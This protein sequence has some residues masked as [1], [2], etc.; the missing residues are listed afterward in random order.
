L[1]FKYIVLIFNII[2]VLF[3]STFA[4]IPFFFPEPESA[5][6]FRHSSW[7]LIIVLSGALIVLNVFF[8]Y[9]YR[10]FWLLER[11]DWPA[12]VDYLER[13]V[14]Q[15]GRY[16]S[17]LARLLINSYLVM[18][19]SAGVTRFESK[20]AIAKPALI[21]ENALVFGVARILGGD[22][23]GAA[24]FF[25]AH[26][27]KGAA[28]ENQW[29][30]WYYGFS[31]ILIRAFDAAEAEL[32]T[33]VPASAN[34]LITGL[35]AYFFSDTLLKHS[36]TKA[37]CRAL[38]EEGRERVKKDLKTIAGWKKETAKIEN[39]VYAAVLKKHIEAAGAW[40]FG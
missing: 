32:K 18:G 13:R 19:D 21:E 8:L 35:S 22:L 36:A 27:A 7:P 17:R 2:I 16:N 6:L 40:L 3:L 33:L 38:A 28:K 1:Q 31:L 15:K 37:E 25:Q 5:A 26:L 24:D 4:F 34:A 39:E 14:I 10:L 30:R 20:A 11:E 23:Q 12:L 9:N 29:L